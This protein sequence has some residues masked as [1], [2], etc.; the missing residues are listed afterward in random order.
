MMLWSISPG[1]SA[2]GNRPPPDC[3]ALPSFALALNSNPRQAPGPEHLL[4]CFGRACPK[5]WWPSGHVAVLPGTIQTF[6]PLRPR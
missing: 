5:L 4:S 3:P 2:I 6:S 1:G